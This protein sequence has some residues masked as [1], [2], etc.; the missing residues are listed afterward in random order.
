MSQDSA[1]SGVM[2]GQE[3]DEPTWSA[4][5]RDIRGSVELLLEKLSR[6]ASPEEMARMTR[7]TEIYFSSLEQFA[8]DVGM[9]KE[10]GP[11]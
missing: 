8:R 2:P 5:A 6:H 7:S 9:G 4:R 1:K 3:R 11:C 10:S